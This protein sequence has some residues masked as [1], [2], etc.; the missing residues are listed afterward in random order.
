MPVTV[1]VPDDYGV[2]VL[3]RLD[4]IRPVRY[5]P[6]EPLPTAAE[7][8]EVLVPAF[9]TGPESIDLAG[10]PKLRLVQMLTA[11][12]ERW[13]GRLPDGVMLSNA[14]GAHGGSSA[15]W[16]VAALLTIYRDLFEFADAR[17]HRHWQYHQTDTL[18]GKRILGIGAG[19]LGIELRRRLEAFD[20]TLTLVGTTARDGVHGVDE[21]PTLLGDF[22]AVVLMVPVTEQT[23]GMVDAQFLAAM[24]DGAILVNVARGPIVQ[25]EALLA[26]LDSGRLRAALDVT[27]PEPLPSDHPLWAAPGLLLTPHVAGSSRGSLDRAYAVVTA[28]IIRYVAGQPPKNL[29]RG[30][31]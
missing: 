26:E 30:D 11:G 12:T 2:G 15:E 10:L 28:E 6:G 21:L 25:T 19:D 9:L 4:G 17:R 24:A 8:A 29:V 3:A 5:T 7:L 13:I 1:L 14:R 18:A 27:D 16:V 22:D 23:I 20:A 31:Y